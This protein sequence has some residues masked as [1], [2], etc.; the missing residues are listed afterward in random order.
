[1]PRAEIEHITGICLEHNGFHETKE[2]HRPIKRGETIDVFSG[3]TRNV[4]SFIAF[5]LHVMR[6]LVL[7]YC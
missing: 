1:M 7:G 5:F 3:C 6:E 2:L 4:K